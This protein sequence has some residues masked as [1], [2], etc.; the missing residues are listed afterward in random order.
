MKLLTSTTEI[1]HCG[2]CAEC[3]PP[4]YMKWK[5]LKTRRV[6]PDIW[7]E[8]PEFCPLPDKEGK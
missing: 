2:K 6:I 5:C 1:E 7:G 4:I 3:G 8:I